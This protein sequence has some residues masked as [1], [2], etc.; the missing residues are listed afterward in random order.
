MNKIFK[1]YKENIYEVVLV[2]GIFVALFFTKLVPVFIGVLFLLW[3]F[4]YK[5]F[6]DF[7]SKRKWI[8]PFVL[9]ALI[10]VGG[11]FFADDSRLALKILERH[12]SFVVL[13]FLIYCKAWSDKNVN[14]FSKFYVRVVVAISV[15]SLLNLLYFYA[16]H[17]AF[18]ETM[19]DTYLQWKLPH[20]IGI[21]PTYFGLLIVVANIIVLNKISNAKNLFKQ[22]GFYI[23]LFL[24]FYLLYLSPRT[25]NLCQILVWLFFGYKRLFGTNSIKINKIFVFITVLLVL[26]LLFATSEYFVDKMMRAFSDKRFML[27]EPAFDVMQSNYFFFGEGLS[28]GSIFLQEYIS[29]NQLT[30]FTG[31]DLHNQYLMNYLDLGIFGLVAILLILLR[32]LVYIKNEVLFLFML[33]FAISMLSES[34]LYVIKGIIIFIILSSYFIIRGLKTASD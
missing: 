13:P 3:I 15:F 19:D 11:C 28:N 16:T 8:W 27:W 7:K 33:V 6:I 9:Y 14:F 1:K 31:T 12:I 24:S 5:S 34:F 29:E 18:V 32:P 20:L 26:V 22:S 10:F 30:Q 4:K 17:T 21:H 2:L 23:A 25:A